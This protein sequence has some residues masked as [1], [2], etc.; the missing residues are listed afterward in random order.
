V[1]TLPHLLFVLRYT[2]KYIGKQF[3][4]KKA[5]GWEHV[6]P[7]FK[8]R[9]RITHPTAPTALK[10]TDED[11]EHIEALEKWLQDCLS[12]LTAA[13]NQTVQRTATCHG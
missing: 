10:I 13:P 6:K 8:I 1:R 11:L 2:A 7:A 5:E 12:E 3:D 4:P 9:D